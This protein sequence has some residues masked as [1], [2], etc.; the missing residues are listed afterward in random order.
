M[1][2]FIHSSER[3]LTSEDNMAVFLV[4]QSDKTLP[5]SLFIQDYPLSS[6]TLVFA[7]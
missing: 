5:K 2:S 1:E 6:I 7:W 4:S 3:F